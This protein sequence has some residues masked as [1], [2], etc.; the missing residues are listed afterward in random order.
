MQLDMHYKNTQ[1]E[2]VIDMAKEAT[3]FH[4]MHDTVRWMGDFSFE[5]M[6]LEGK[7]I[8]NC[9]HCTNCGADIE[10]RVPF[11]DEE[12]EDVKTECDSSST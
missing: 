4:C 7:G 6:G 10:Y 8:V 2:R 1:I 3:C 5:E 12:D 11:N 9:C